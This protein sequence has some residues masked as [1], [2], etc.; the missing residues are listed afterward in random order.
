MT[1]FIDSLAWSAAVVTGLAAAVWLCSALLRRCG[2]AVGA[3]PAL[4]VLLLIPV[5]TLFSFLPR[6]ANPIPAPAPDSVVAATRPDPATIPIQADNPLTP[7]LAE[8]G[9]AP[10]DL[11]AAAAPEMAATLVLLPW[12]DWLATGWERAA[13]WIAGGLAIGLALGWLRL[14]AGVY[15]IRSLLRKSRPVKDA[16]ISELRDVL[17]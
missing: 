14:A 12:R 7:A 13:P 17:C 10:T 8:T 2:V 9:A 6:R 4:A 3:T 11:P 5:V 16:E 15:S 1:Y